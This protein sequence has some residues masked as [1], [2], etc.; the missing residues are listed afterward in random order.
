VIVTPEDNKIVVFSKGNPHGSKA[1]I[2]SGG[3]IHPISI[4]ED[5]L[6]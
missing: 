3:Q 6:P 2:F 1:L 4:E 5:K